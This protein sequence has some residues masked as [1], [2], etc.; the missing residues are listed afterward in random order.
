MLG[1][2]YKYYRRPGIIVTTF[3]V[4][5]MNDEAFRVVVTTTA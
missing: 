2:Y 1:C 4:G 3:M 5:Y